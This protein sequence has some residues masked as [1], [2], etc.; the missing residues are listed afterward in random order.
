MSES[1]NPY[2]DLSAARLE[3]LLRDVNVEE[4]ECQLRLR[5]A[6]LK[7]AQVEQALYD[8]KNKGK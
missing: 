1:V 2:R 3:R 4:A 7:R 6:F 5:E 8:A